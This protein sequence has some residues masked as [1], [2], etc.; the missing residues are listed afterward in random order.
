[1]RCRISGFGGEPWADKF[2]LP[3]NSNNLHFPLCN[4]WTGPLIRCLS[5]KPSY[6]LF[7]LL[8][9]LTNSISKTPNSSHPCRSGHA[10][11]NT[12][13]SIKKTNKISRNPIDQRKAYD[14]S[15]IIIGKISLLY[16]F[17]KTRHAC[18]DRRCLQPTAQL[19]QQ[20]VS[21]RKKVAAGHLIKL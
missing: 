13:K 21:L 2:P 14:M 12:I 6:P 15:Q 17:L 7:L 20:E 19:P 16:E 18:G 9:I 8:L 11:G 4:C 1:M 10:I 5:T 3:D